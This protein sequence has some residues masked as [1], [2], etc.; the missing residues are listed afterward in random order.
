VLARPVCHQSIL[1]R[2]LELI[3]LL[4]G[5]MVPRARHGSME[6]Y[7]HA[8]GKVVPAELTQERHRELNPRGEHR[9]CD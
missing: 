3:K 7:L 6:H 8:H 4:K 9:R 2:N 5:P 1:F